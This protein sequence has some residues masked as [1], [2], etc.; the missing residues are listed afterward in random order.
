M[1][2]R[3]LWISNLDNPA[4]ILIID[5]NRGKVAELRGALNPMRRAVSRTLRPTGRGG[6][7]SFCRPAP[8]RPPSARAMCHS[9]GFELAETQ[10]VGCLGGNQGLASALSHIRV[11]VVSALAVPETQAL[12]R[13]MGGLYRR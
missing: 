2:K 12:L 10:L 6:G 9:F 11:L 3:L 4:Q 13:A 1:R 5:D 8:V 7:S